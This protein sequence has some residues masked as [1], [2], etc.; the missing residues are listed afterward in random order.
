MVIRFFKKGTRHM[1]EPDTGEHNL[2]KAFIHAGD[3]VSDTTLR[4]GETSLEGQPKQTGSDGIN[5]VEHPLNR[6]TGGFAAAGG[7]RFAFRNIAAG[8]ELVELEL[9]RVVGTAARR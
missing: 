4:S 2:A 3:R 9:K 1:A 7:T 5:L 6:V 8:I